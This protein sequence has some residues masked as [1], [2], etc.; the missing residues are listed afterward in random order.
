MAVGAETVACVLLEPCGT[1]ELGVIG[2]GTLYY[3]AGPK[4]KEDGGIDAKPSD[5]ACQKSRKDATNK[6]VNQLF[7]PG[8]GGPV[9]ASD[10]RRC[11]RAIVQ[12]TGCDY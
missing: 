8:S 9:S 11:I 6:C 5:S 12:P 2:L 3:L 7:G 10:L 4:E 1:F